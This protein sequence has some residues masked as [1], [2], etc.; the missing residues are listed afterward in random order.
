MSER[1][2]HQYSYSAKIG[3]YFHNSQF[4]LKRVFVVL[5]HGTLLVL[6]GLCLIQPVLHH[7]AISSFL[8]SHPGQEKIRSRNFVSSLLKISNCLVHLDTDRRT[9]KR[10]A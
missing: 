5:N 1:H 6:L 3:K 9:Y 10:S 7:P 8:G 4:V 2:L